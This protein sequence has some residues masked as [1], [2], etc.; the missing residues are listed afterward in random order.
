M[1]F[2]FNVY[3]TILIICGSVTLFFSY[4]VYKKEGGA[5]RFFGIMMLANAIWALG[6]GFELASPTLEQATIYINIQYLGITA[7]PLN[8]FL[9]CLH[10]SG[11]EAWYKRK[12]NLIFLISVSVITTLLVWTNDYHHLHYERLYMDTSGDF[13][14]VAIEPAIA[15][16][17]FTVYFYALLAIG[18]YLL[19]IKFRQADPIYRRQNYMIIISAMI[20]WAANISYLTGLRPVPNLDLT[21]FAFIATVFMISLAIYRFKLFDILP[22]AREKV[23]DLMQDGFVVLDHR[24]RVIDYNRSFK[25]YLTD[26]HNSKIIGTPI[27]ALMPDQTLLFDYLNRKESGKIE[28]N[29]QTPNGLYAI[30][31][32]IRYLNE[33]QLSSEATIIKLQDLTS[34]R[35]ESLRSRL[36]A[37]ELQRLNQLKDRIFSIIAHDLRGPLVNLSEV[38]KMISNNLISMEEFKTLVPALSKD[39]LYTTDLLENILH[40]SRSQLKGYGI[41]HEFFDLKSLVVNEVN[42]HLPSAKSKNIEIIQDVFPG[43]TVYADIIMMEIVVRNIL[44]NAIKFCQSG[45]RIHITAV[46]T[47]EAFIR[48]SIADNGLGM[49]K[50][51][52]EKLFT[53]ENQSTR[54]TANE[55]GTG[56]GL[57][58]CK[59][60]VERNNGMLTV[61]SEQG[62]GSTFNIYL[63]VDDRDI[64][65]E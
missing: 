56:L 15:Y 29:V 37:E 60:F 62:V 64:E 16:R 55:K 17:L 14:M 58:V 1:E 65:L 52:L 49:P 5:V 20:P 35:E 19:I 31:A 12:R 42:Y 13:P 7:L 2:S 22:V 18:S 4:Y 27:S 34:L 44:N 11:K 47:K 3:S 6:Y 54:G 41:N 30:E 39:I 57:V 43:A 33:N 53:G 50:E 28:L 23:L 36:Q 32:D 25:T 48:L 51:V 38:L 26:Y 9:F 21:P 40:W 63:P 45:C 46:Y 61:E 8:W 24:N 10:L 59:D